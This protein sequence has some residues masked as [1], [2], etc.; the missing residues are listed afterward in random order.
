MKESCTDD[1]KTALTSKYECDLPLQEKKNCT[2]PEMF[3][4]KSFTNFHFFH[5]LLLPFHT[6][7]P[8]KMFFVLIIAFR[9][10]SD[11]A[12]YERKTLWLQKRCLNNVIYIC[13]QLWIVQNEER[14]WSSSQSVKTSDVGGPFCVKSWKSAVEIEDNCTH[15]ASLDPSLVLNHCRRL[16]SRRFW[17]QNETNTDLLLSA[18]A[19][20]KMVIAHENCWQQKLTF[21]SADW[22]QYCT[23]QIY[24]DL[25][26]K[27][28]PEGWNMFSELLIQIV[29]KPVFQR[30]VK[31]HSSTQ[32]HAIDVRKQ[33]SMKAICFI[34]VHLALYVCSVLKIMPKCVFRKNTAQVSIFFRSSGVL[35]AKSSLRGGQGSSQ[36]ILVGR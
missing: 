9:T 6:Y 34:K 31:V 11:F 29:Q 30:I 23:P 19:S 2:P 24:C 7:S 10:C 18:T 12:W 20:N 15:F 35:T 13:Y 3:N 4:H 36:I 27:Q 22:P 17:K 16:K 26:R 21:K 28:G 5:I 25:Q 14:N 8:W 32:V 1:E 33:W